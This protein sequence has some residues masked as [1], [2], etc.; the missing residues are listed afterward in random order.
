MAELREDR[1]T[2]GDPSFMYVGID[3]FG[4]FRGEA[5][6]VT[7]QEVRLLIPLLYDRSTL[8]SYTR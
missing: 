6:V 7:R 3:C 8:R 1:L 2:Q 4:T 5:G